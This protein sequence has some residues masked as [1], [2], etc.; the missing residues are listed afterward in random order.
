MP[1]GITAKGLATRQRIVEG[2]AEVVRTRGVAA[3]GLEDIREATG[4]S[5]GQMTHYFP[6]GKTEL[7]LAVARHEGEQILQEQRPLLDDL[8][9][10]TAWL[11]WADD[12]VERHERQ[13]EHCGLSTLLGQLEPGDLGVRQVLLELFESWGNALEQGIRAMQRA[14]EMDPGAD[15]REYARA[16]LASVQGGVVMLLATGSSDYFRSALDTWF[17]RLR[18]G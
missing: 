17:A 13:R 8:T 14:G 2:A 15:P 3:T 11:A 10:W 1:R 9:S 16:L 7:L 4:T 12:L 6:G 5:G 18:V